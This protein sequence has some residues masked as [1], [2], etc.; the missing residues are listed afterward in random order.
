MPQECKSLKTVTPVPLMLDKEIMLLRRTKLK[1]SQ[2]S[3]IAMDPMD[4][5]E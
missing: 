5:R 1:L 4:Q 3:Q 2:L